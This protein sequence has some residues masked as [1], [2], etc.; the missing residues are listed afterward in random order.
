MLNMNVDQMASPSHINEVE[1]E[2]TGSILYVYGLYCICLLNKKKQVWKFYCGPY[3]I[4]GSKVSYLL[5]C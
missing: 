5:C 2:V 1:V 3:V 4:H